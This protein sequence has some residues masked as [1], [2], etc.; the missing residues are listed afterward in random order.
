MRIRRIITTT[1]ALAVASVTLVL[2]ASTAQ[3]AEDNLDA[4]MC[5]GAATDTPQE[6]VGVA[7]LTLLAAQ[8]IPLTG[9]AGTVHQVSYQ[10][11]GGYRCDLVKVHVPAAAEGQRVTITSRAFGQV[12]VTDRAG[13]AFL[14]DGYEFIYNQVPLPTFSMPAYNQVAGTRVLNVEVYDT[15]TTTFTSGS[16]TYYETAQPMKWALQ[17]N[18]DAGSKSVTTPPTAETVAK[19]AGVRDAA[20]A[21]S[22][23][24]LK[25][26]RLKAKKVYDRQLAAAD[27]RKERRAAKRTYVTAVKNAKRQ[28]AA[29]RTRIEAAYKTAI[30]PVAT[31]TTFVA[32]A[33][34]P[35]SGQVPP[36][37]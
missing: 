33:S 37:A 17:V 8:D 36:T 5:A 1:A 19:A 18:A 25:K 13:Y 4:R 16:T 6:G 28:H 9:I 34:A 30:A 22:V 21:A 7:S 11:P 10:L 26:A 23:K 15:S 2:P 29:R 27:T 20:I 31:T 3:A 35:I 24:T 12:H 32:G 14:R